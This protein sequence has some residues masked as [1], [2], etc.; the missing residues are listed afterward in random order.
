MAD[1]LKV[2]VWNVESF[3]DGRRPHQFS[4][5]RNKWRQRAV[6]AVIEA[7]GI[8]L[9]LIMETGPDAGA[10]GDAIVARLGDDH[11]RV[12]SK[13]TG[14]GS[15]ERDGVVTDTN[16]API[17]AGESYLAVYN[18]SKLDDVSPRL[19][20]YGGEAV[21]RKRVSVPSGDIRGGWRLDVKWNG[22]AAGQQGVSLFVL[23]A[24]SPSYSV[25]ARETVMSHYARSL[26]DDVAIMCGDFNFKRSEQ[27]RLP[28]AITGFSRG[29]GDV[30]DTS[31]R[32]IRGIGEPTS[33]FFSGSQPYDQV[34]CR[35]AAP[36]LAA[37]QVRTAAS[38]MAVIGAQQELGKDIEKL[39]ADLKSSNRPDWSALGRVADVRRSDRLNP[40]SSQFHASVM[41]S[42]EL[43]RRQLRELKG[44]P[45]VAE[46]LTAVD[47]L[48]KRLQPDRAVGSKAKVGDGSEPELGRLEA[49]T[50]L[51]LLEKN[52]TRLLITLQVDSGG[53]KGDGWKPVMAY[54][55][56]VSDH[57]P[58]SFEVTVP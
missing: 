26:P 3:T 18:K 36:R 5:S 48:E 28:G 31:L 29:A 10:F 47:Q 42:I 43:C 17:Y 7:F 58:I 45:G 24:P 35:P 14:L 46:A 19:V 44:Q 50:Y 21:K 6:A 11:R 25:D 37:V 27:H 32:S 53:F 4:R 22:R 8:D 33:M 23:H 12:A 13:V 1:R 15:T 9:C 51:D 34:W 52:M 54:H 41:E 30:V 49:D 39:W 40:T 38:V 2:L 56:L 55:S 16:G 20:P 57:L